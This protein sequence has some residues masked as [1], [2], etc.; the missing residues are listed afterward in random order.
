MKQTLPLDRQAHLIPVKLTLWLTEEQELALDTLARA[1][2]AQ[3]TPAR[4]ARFV[5]DLLRWYV[6]VDDEGVLGG[7][8]RGA[9]GWYDAA[10][11][12][13]QR[14]RRPAA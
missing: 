4:R 7:N 2:E 14:P 10:Q 1:D 5:Y 13:L 3:V 9:G 8:G 6:Q 11:A 12:K